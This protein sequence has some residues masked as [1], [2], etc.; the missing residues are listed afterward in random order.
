MD[1]LDRYLEEMYDN[2]LMN[3]F[4]IR[5]SPIQGNGVFATKPLRKGDLINTHFKAGT[6]ITDF[7]ANLNHSSSPNAISKKQEDGG[8]K[9]YAE[10]NIEPDDEITLD[11]TVNQ[12]LEQPQK[13][14]K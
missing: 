3:N 14:W 12:D 6:Q 1:L 4:A 10:K 5:P 7:G 13:G 8:Y 11:Y 9:T 2:D